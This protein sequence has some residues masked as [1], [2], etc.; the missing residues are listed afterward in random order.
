MDAIEAHD[1]K[2]GWDGDQ[3]VRGLLDHEWH[4]AKCGCTVK[5]YA[6]PPAYHVVTTFD[7]KAIDHEVNGEGSFSGTCGEIVAWKVMHS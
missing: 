3:E 7:S 4:C 5:G 2:P 1:W 6:K